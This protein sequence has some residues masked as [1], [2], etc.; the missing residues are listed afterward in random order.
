MYEVTV[1]HGAKKGKIVWSGPEITVILTEC[2]RLERSHK[3]LDTNY[4]ASLS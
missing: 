1:V 2:L 4:I 3:A